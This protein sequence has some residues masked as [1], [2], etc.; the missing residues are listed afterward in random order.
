MTA[1]YVCDAEL[2]ARRG[3]VPLCIKC[4]GGDNEDTPPIVTPVTMKPNVTF[5]IPAP[6]KACELAGYSIEQ[7]D[8]ATEGSRDPSLYRKL[9]A[10]Q[11]ARRPPDAT[12]ALREKIAAWSKTHAKAQPDYQFSCLS[13]SWSDAGVSLVHVTADQ[14]RDNGPDPRYNILSITTHDDGTYTI[15]RTLA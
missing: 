2:D 8:Y 6:C 15:E 1:C 7:C 10:E 4:K 3:D 11:E 9:L 14:M 12:D 13:E 5:S